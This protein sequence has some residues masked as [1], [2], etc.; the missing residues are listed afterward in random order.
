MSL[1]NWF[2]VLSFHAY[3]SYCQH[4]TSSGSLALGAL[5]FLTVARQIGAQLCACECL[6]P[7]FVQEQGRPE[8]KKHIVVP[9]RI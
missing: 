3:A 9:N 7:S 5:L 8:N 4:A 2:Q 1:A 6:K